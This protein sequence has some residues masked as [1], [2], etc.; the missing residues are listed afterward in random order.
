MKIT[1]VFLG[2]RL[3]LQVVVLVDKT[4]FWSYVDTS[5]APKDFPPSVIPDTYTS[6]YI[7][8]PRMFL[9]T[10]MYNFLSP[11]APTMYISR[12]VSLL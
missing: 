10:H 5:C 7:S 8:P 3:L 6:R 1:P 2:D 9:A 4:N 12:Q 11:T